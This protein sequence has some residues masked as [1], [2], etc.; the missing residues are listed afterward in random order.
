MLIFFMPDQLKQLLTGKKPKAETGPFGQSFSSQSIE[1]SQRLH[2]GD[3]LKFS[4][5]QEE[6]TAWRRRAV[7]G[8]M[9]L[10]P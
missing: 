3:E 4:R 9:P 10:A 1:T 7:H 8:W 6:G 5:T 2:K